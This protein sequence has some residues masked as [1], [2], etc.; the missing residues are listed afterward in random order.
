MS[1]AEELAHEVLRRQLVETGYVENLA[2]LFFGDDGAEEHHAD[3]SEDWASFSAYI[4]DVTEELD[5][6]AVLL[7]HRPTRRDTVSAIYLD[8][9]T[10]RTEELLLSLPGL[11]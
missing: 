11:N 9:R 5:P 10:N 3:P 1:R 2:L 6:G 7:I 4:E 8:R